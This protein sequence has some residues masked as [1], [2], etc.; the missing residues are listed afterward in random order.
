MI[1]GLLLILV[2][3]VVVAGTMIAV[4]ARRKGAENAIRDFAVSQG[5]RWHAWGNGT[6]PSFGIG[7]GEHYRF[8]V[9]FPRQGMPVAALESANPGGGSAKVW[10]SVRVAAPVTPRLCLCKIGPLDPPDHPLAQAF[11]SSRLLGVDGVLAAWPVP[12]P[13]L[14]PLIAVYT[15]DL[16]F[17]NS[18]VTPAFLRWFAGAVPPLAPMIDIEAGVA[19]SYIPEPMD[20]ASLTTTADRLLAVTR[21]LAVP[22]SG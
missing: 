2:I 13:S 22:R 19:R 17:A 8:A 15:A 6:T 3:V 9:E 10:H 12:D 21:A 16:G 14:R 11:I 7:P 1:A 18:V 5:G 4:F 20:V